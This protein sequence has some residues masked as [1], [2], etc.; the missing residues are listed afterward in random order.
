MNK[1]DRDT[2]TDIAL[3]KLLDYYKLVLIYLARDHFERKLWEAGG[4]YLLSRTLDN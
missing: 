3:V 1:S 2:F 4:T